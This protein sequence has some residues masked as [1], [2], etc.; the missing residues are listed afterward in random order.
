M[1][2]YCIT[3][4]LKC[5]E[6]DIV[7]HWRC[8]YYTLIKHSECFIRVPR[9]PQNVLDLWICRESSDSQNPGNLALLAFRV[10]SGDNVLKE[11]FL[12]A[13]RNAQYTSQMIQNDLIAL[14]GKYIQKLY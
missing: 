7:L 10:D 9:F 4:H 1:R 8:L 12:T 11:H 14:I 2:L 5:V 3:K 13:P 6:Y